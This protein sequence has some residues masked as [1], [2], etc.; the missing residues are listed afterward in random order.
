MHMKTRTL[1]V[2]VIK[3]SYTAS[4][5]G[6]SKDLF[7]YHSWKVKV[8]NRTYR[9]KPIQGSLSSLPVTR[10]GRGSVLSP[11]RYVSQVKDAISSH[12]GYVRQES[13]VVLDKEES[14][15]LMRAQYKILIKV[16]SKLLKVAYTTNDVYTFNVSLD[17][18]S[19]VVKRYEAFVQEIL[20]NA[21]EKPEKVELYKVLDGLK[22]IA[23]TD[24]EA[25]KRELEV[26]EER[27]KEN[28]KYS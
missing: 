22:S 11:M 28:R 26:I 2:P 27:I 15:K 25:A 12:G 8:K 13:P 5:K 1:K 17:R 23:E 14:I 7:G 24:F 9:H 6:I 21:N 10:V 19:S 20:R 18:A 4:G 3:I 16:L